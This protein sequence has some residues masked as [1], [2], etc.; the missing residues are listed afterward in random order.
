MDSKN[1]LVNPFGATLREMRRRKDI[2]QSELA[3]RLRCSDSTISNWE[4][5]DPKTARL[6]SIVQYQTLTEALGLSRS[7]ERLLQTDYTSSEL[8]MRFG[9]R[10]A[11][12]R[13]RLSEVQGQR[14][15]DIGDLDNAIYFF[16]RA[17]EERSPSEDRIAYVN[18][19]KALAE[20]YSACESYFEAL[21]SLQKAESLPLDAK[22]KAQLRRQKGI[23]LRRMGR[24]DEAQ[25]E[26]QEALDFWENPVP[27]MGDPID[28][29]HD[30]A[31]TLVALADVFRVQND[32]DGAAEL[33][34][35]AMRIVDEKGAELPNVDA[36]KR[37]GA[38][39][40][41]AFGR[42]RLGQRQ[43]DGEYLVEGAFSIMQSLQGGLRDAEICA[44]ILGEYFAS[45]RDWSN[46]RRW[47]LECFLIDTV[48]GTAIR[49]NDILLLLVETARVLGQATSESIT[50]YVYDQI[51][52]AGT[53][54]QKA[55]IRLMRGN[56]ALAA[57]RVREA[58][59]NY[60]QLIQSVVFVPPVQHNSL[61]ESL[62][63]GIRI[64][65][66]PRTTISVA[67]ELLSWVQTARV[68]DELLLEV[69]ANQRIRYAVNALGV[70]Q[71]LMQASSHHTS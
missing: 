4:S 11:A 38:Q 67:N 10:T 25:R 53:H 45:I 14:R 40:K 15:W 23:I 64:G 41:Y 50:D 55:R 68:N 28:R 16:E 37:L 35:Q 69:E 6:P 71:Y 57:G 17:L 44:R 34:Q 63:L 62:V 60:R 13:I 59:D 3:F 39:V 30:R 66:A 58:V 61:L 8:R 49:K 48:S 7:E 56:D 26:L 21:A 31:Q 27:L 70:V 2:K 5:Q 51:L 18:N 19:L 54:R 65:I 20:I 33:S 36:A 22:S 29:V 12:V 52:D 43:R 47:L 9:G 46:A 42:V 32:L 1:R 24:Y